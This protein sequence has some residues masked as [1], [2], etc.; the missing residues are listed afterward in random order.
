MFDIVTKEIDMK[1]IQA[2]PIDM[3]DL[4]TYY[5]QYHPSQKNLKFKHAVPSGINAYDMAAFFIEDQVRM[6]ENSH[7]V[8]DEVPIFQQGN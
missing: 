4:I 3:R 2:Q 6:H 7:F 8:L 5:N 1:H